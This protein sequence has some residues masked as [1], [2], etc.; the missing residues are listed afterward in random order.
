MPTPDF[1]HDGKITGLD[2]YIENELAN[3]TSS[4]NYSSPGC[5]TGFIIF[6][7]VCLI[8]WLIVGE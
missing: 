2:H 3:G 5:G 1:N 4:D 6:M 8:L 7:A